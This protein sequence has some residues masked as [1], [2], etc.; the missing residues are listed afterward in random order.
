ME[1]TFPIQ[2]KKFQPLMIFSDRMNRIWAILETNLW[3]Y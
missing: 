2:K 3:K 1:G